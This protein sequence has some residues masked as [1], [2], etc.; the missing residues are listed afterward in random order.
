MNLFLLTVIIV[1]VAALVIWRGIAWYQYG[2][3]KKDL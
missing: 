1:A 2:F 3:H